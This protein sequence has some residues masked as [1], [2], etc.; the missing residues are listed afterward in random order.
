MRILKLLWSVYVYV[1]TTYTIVVCFFFSLWCTSKIHKLKSWNLKFMPIIKIST[2]VCILPDAINWN[3]CK[4]HFS[5][6]ENLG[7]CALNW[8]FKGQCWTLLNS[9]SNNYRTSH[10]IITVELKQSGFLPWK[11]LM[12]I[13]KLLEFNNLFDILNLLCVVFQ[14]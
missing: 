13:R 11:E 9:V 7:N 6:I 2:V 5:V 8:T 4:Y 12:M 3:V 10:I 14:K 1:F